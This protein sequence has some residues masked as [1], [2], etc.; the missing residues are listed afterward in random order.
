M[1]DMSESR[2]AITRP[3]PHTLAMVIPPVPAGAPSGAD[4]APGEDAVPGLTVAAVARRLGVAPATLRTWDRR[5]GLGPSAH[6]AGAH[7]R[8]SATDLGRLEMMRRLV[9]EGIAPADAARHV[10]ACQIEPGP[11]VPSLATGPVPA[12]DPP[13]ASAAADL[14]T[15]SE[16]PRART[17]GGRVVPLHGGSPR[18][19]GLARAALALDSPS[20][21]R[22]IT[23]S[24]AE[25]GV[26]WTWDTLVA[27]V[28]I[29]VGERFQSTGQGVDLEHLL[30]EGV[31]SAL[32]D[33]IDSAPEV[34]GARPVLLAAAPDEQHTLPLYAVAAAL[35]ERGVPT[36]LLGARVPHDALVSAVRRI[37]PPAVM[38]WSHDPITGDLHTLAGISASRPAP[39]VVVGGPGWPE[40]L[41]PEVC[42]VGDLSDAITRLASAARGL[43]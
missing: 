20:V 42:R 34:D 36:R 29:G 7:R 30:S 5:Y 31:V 10:L 35:A 33:V 3:R 15:A 14:A 13:S 41:P 43:G 16:A 1:P 23:E 8:Y 24:V 27:P 25:R 2:V 17:G 12:V 40:V 37:G 39:V 21:R 9:F 26:I 19:R 18:A 22:I 4:P 28:L 32:R 6:T 38:V 11:V